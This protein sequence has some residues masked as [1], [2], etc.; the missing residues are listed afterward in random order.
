MSKLTIE[1]LREVLHY[2]PKTGVWTWLVQLSLRGQKSSRAGAI[3]GGAYGGYRLI[4]IDGEHFRSSRLAY[5]Y[6]TGRWPSGHI[7]HANLDKGDDRWENLREATGT[8][9]NANWSI[10]CKNKSGL[11]GVS[12]SKA[13]GKWVA[14]LQVNRRN[15]NLGYFTDK[16]EAAAAYERAPRA[17]RLASLRGR[18]EG[19][20]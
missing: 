2:D 12:W 1:R 14:Y 9:N 13:N 20:L 17:K 19:P 15:R 18:H 3:K 7:D 8:Q 6:M 11:K 10:S 4:G 5:F 16:Y